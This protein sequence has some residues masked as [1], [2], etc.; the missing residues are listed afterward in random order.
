MKRLSKQQQQTRSQLI[1]ALRK[2]QSKLA[3]AVDDANAIIDNEIAGAVDAYNEALGELSSFRDEIVGEM[4]TYADERS[5]KWRE[6][7]AGSSYEEWKNE[8][9]GLDMDELDQFEPLESPEPSH[10]DDAEA[11]PEEVSS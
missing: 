3:K 10:A 9:E 8:W 2:A 7:E 5:D 4:E 6:S 1:E 11:L